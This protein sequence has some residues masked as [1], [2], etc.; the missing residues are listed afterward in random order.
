[1]TPAGRVAWYI[2]GAILLGFLAFDLW[3][4][5]TH[6]DPSIVPLII[7]LVVYLCVPV[8]VEEVSYGGNGGSATRE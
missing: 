8:F 6:G 4:E 1:M 3:A 5:S 7:G 2:I